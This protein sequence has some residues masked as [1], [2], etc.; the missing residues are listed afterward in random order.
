MIAHDW[1]ELLGDC[2]DFTRRLVQTPSMPGQESAVADLIAQEMRDLAFDQ[3][4]QDGIGNVYGRLFGQDR[5]AGA[6]VLNSHVDHVDPGDLSCWPVPPYSAEVAGDR[7]LGRA[8]CDIKGPLAVQVYAM[9]ALRRAGQRPPRD[10]VFSGVVQEEIGGAG[11]AYWVRHLDYPVALIVLGEP[12]SNSISLGHRGMMQMWVTFGGRSVHA[13]VPERGDNPNYRLARFLERLEASQSELGVHTLLGPT[14]VAPTIVEVDTS[15][16]NVTPAWSRVLLDFRSATESPNS[17]RRFVLRLA[18]EPTPD[19]FDAISAEPGAPL[20][21]SD[22]PLAGFYTSPDHPAVG[23]A[24]AAISRGMGWT[25]ELTRYQFA[26]DG[27]LFVDVGAPI[28]GYSP[29]EEELAHTVQ[30]S[31][32][33]PMMA[34]SLKGYVQLLLDF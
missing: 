28:I 32:S 23:R 1:D 14:T 19:L 15:S 8:T 29:A 26:T 27:R 33:I 11:A 12:S 31:I 22:A 18:G 2:V 17:L 16:N 24:R 25:P 5:Q 9:A 10:V 7:I 6:I 21:Q 13:S 3:V 30:E 20:H 4:W 34:D